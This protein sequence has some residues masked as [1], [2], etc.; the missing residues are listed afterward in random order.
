MRFN[1]FIKTRFGISIGQ[2][3]DAWMVGDGLNNLRNLK[4]ISTL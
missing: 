4:H 2:P 3:I 1:F